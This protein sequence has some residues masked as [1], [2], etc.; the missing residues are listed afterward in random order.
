MQTRLLLQLTRKVRLGLRGSIPC[1]NPWVA[2]CYFAHGSSEFPVLLPFFD[3][4]S[5]STSVSSSL[6]AQSELV[7]RSLL[8]TRGSVHTINHHNRSEERRVGKECRS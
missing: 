6:N 8:L 7:F 1:Q 3:A 2:N 5:P 4:S